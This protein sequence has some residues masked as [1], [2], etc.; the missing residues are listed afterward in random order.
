M[1]CEEMIRAYWRSALAQNAEEMASYFAHGAWI[2]WHNSDEH[3]TVEEFIRANCEYPDRWNGDIER[4]H[5]LDHL[6]I[7]VVHVYNLDHTLSFH[8]TSFININDAGRICSI[9]EYWGDDG[10][11]PAWRKE[12]HIGTSLQNHNK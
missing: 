11:A 12:K 2:N 1:K 3:F 5:F 4:L 8:V 7:C 9:D 6:V 10:E